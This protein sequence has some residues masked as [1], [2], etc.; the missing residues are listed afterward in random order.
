MLGR[1]SRSET[2]GLLGTGVSGVS[3]SQERS[4][5]PLCP[6]LALSQDATGSRRSLYYSLLKNLLSSWSS[7]SLPV[8]PPFFVSWNFSWCA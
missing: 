4:C 8:L 7:S 3:P 6:R 5:H 1:A 2:C